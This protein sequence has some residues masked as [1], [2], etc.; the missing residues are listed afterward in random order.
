MGVGVVRQRQIYDNMLTTADRVGFGKK[1]TV[2]PRFKVMR[3]PQRLNGFS[4]GIVT[5][6]LLD[7]IYEKRSDQD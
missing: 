2:N 5:Q 4:I 3:C 1:R 6:K 7:V